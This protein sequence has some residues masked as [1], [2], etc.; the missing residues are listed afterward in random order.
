MYFIKIYLIKILKYVNG[1]ILEGNW[2][3]DLIEGEGVY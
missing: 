1:D 3:Y 2:E